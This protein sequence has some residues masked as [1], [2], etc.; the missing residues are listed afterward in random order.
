MSV[1]PSRSRR[2]LADAGAWRGNGSRS[3]RWRGEIDL[4]G[5]AVAGEFVQAD[6]RGERG[7]IG[8]DGGDQGGDGIGRGGGRFVLDV[9]AE[10]GEHL[11]KLRGEGAQERRSRGHRGDCNF[12]ADEG[13][14]ISGEKNRLPVEKLEVARETRG[15]QGSLASARDDTL[16]NTRWHSHTAVSYG[17][18]VSC[19]TAL[20]ARLCEIRHCDGKVNGS[21]LAAQ[22]ARVEDGA[23]ELFPVRDSVYGVSGLRRPPD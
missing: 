2:R 14:V 19:A 23:P 7:E 18:A 17:M 6:A 4:Q 9:A 11:G 1:W 22:R 5:G 8:G 13:R 10:G 3:G 12:V 15:V 20:A 16:K 21:T